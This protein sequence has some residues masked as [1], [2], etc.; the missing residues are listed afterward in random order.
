[1]YYDYYHGVYFCEGRPIGAKTIKP[2]STRLDGWLFSQSQLKSLD[3]VKDAMVG[4]VRKLGGN[5]VVDF[6]YYQKSSF[7]RSL[8]SVDDVRWEAT[9]IIA[10]IDLCH[11]A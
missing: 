5:S 4:E 6:K 11:I 1:M 7:W 2:V 10:R 3:D 9:G 8:F